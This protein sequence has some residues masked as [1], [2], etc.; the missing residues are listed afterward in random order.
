MQIEL[1]NAGHVALPSLEAPRPLLERAFARAK[2]EA[3]TTALKGS[4]T[5][6]TRRARA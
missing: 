1:S 4:A 6:T 3:L 5:S 2:I